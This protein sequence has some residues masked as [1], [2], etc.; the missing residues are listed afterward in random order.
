MILIY[1]SDAQIRNSDSTLLLKSV[2]QQ[3]AT[4]QEYVN[5]NAPLY[6]G[7]SYIKYWNKVIG[8]PYFI[9]DQF[10]N[11]DINYQNYYYYNIPLKYDLVKNQLVILNASKEFE[12]TLINDH[13]SEFKISSHFFI[14]INIDSSH[15]YNPGPGF[16]ELV[17]PGRSAVIIKYQKRVEASLKAEDNTS[18][19]AAYSNYY[20]F[21]KN[22]YHE[23]S[24]I[25]DFFNIHKDYRSVLKKY[26]RKEKSN[27]SKDPAKALILLASY[28]DTV[29]H[30]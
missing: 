10:Q 25:S 30:E 3:K 7:T 5:V 1:K 11:A 14:K 17:Y 16:Y 9:S 24:S 27:F 13:I 18:S 4:F 26:M 23:I 29:S 8:H 21:S 22:E 19:F 12:M 15:A 6:N 20:V 2:Q 28:F